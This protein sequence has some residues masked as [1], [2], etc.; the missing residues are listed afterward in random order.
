MKKILAGAALGA[1][2]CVMPAVAQT[3]PATP[4]AT[5]PATPSAPPPPSHCG[6]IP[7]APQFPHGAD[8][9][10][11]EMNAANTAYQTWASDAHTKLECRREEVS[12]LMAQAVAAREDFNASVNQLSGVTTA[13]QAEVDAYNQRHP[14]GHR[15]EERLH[16]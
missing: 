11:T 5:A 6:A 10:A 12:T 14:S 2:L 8:A 4:G 16:H 1:L 9:S 7:A 13:W 15:P 3:P